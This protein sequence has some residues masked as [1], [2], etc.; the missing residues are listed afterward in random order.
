VAADRVEDRV[1]AGVTRRWTLVREV[2]GAEAW[3]IA[4]PSGTGLR[5]HGHGGSKA[6]LV[7]VRG[8]LRERYLAA[9][10]TL[11]VRWLVP[12]DAVELGVD[13]QHEVVNVDGNEAVSVHAYSPPLVEPIFR[14]SEEISGAAP[15]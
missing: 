6:S 7:V 15:R 3:V 10:G 2:P 11:V 14:E 8:R 1:P 9:D 5:L 13:H 4:W 12:G